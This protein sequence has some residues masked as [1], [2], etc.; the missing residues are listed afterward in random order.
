M[1][2]TGPAHE[3]DDVHRHLELG[4]VS[5]LEGGRPCG[6]GLLADPI[7]VVTCAHVV[8]T[9]LGR[10][11]RAADQPEATVPVAFPYAERVGREGRVVVWRPVG[12]AGG[13][14][15]VLELVEPAPPE[16]SPVRLVA[17][18]ALVDHAFVVWGFPQGGAGQ[19]LAEGVLSRRRGDDLVQMRAGDGQPVR[20]GYSGAPVWDEVLHGVVGIVTSSDPDATTRTAY[21]LPTDVIAGV[22]PDLP[23]QA[24]E[25]VDAAHIE[26]PEAR[27]VVG[28]RI[29]AA[30]ES[31]RDR[32]ELRRKLRELLLEGRRIICVT[33]RRGIGKSAVVAKVLAEF[34]QPDPARSPLDDLDGLVY[35]STRTQSGVLSLATVFDA[36]AS[37]ADDET[38]ARL[39]RRWDNAKGAALPA[40]WEAVRRTRVVV[41]LDNLDDV[42]D[43]DTGRLQALDLLQ[44]L[45]SVCRTPYPQRVVTT[46]QRSLDLPVELLPNVHEERLEEGLGPE[47]ALA[48]PRAMQGASPGLAAATDDQ[49]VDA[50]DRLHGVPR[51]LELLAR[52]VNRDPFFLDD[53]LA[54]DTAPG[55]L[56][57]ELVSRSFTGLDGVGRRVVALL[58]LAAVPLAEPD[59]ATM[60]AGTAGMAGTAG[61]AA[62][63][64]TADA[65]DV[66]RSVRALVA[67][68]QLG[69]DSVARHVRLHPLDADYVQH[70]LLADEPGT[71]VD[72]D[73][74]LA[75][76]YAAAR[77]PESTWRAVADVTPLR[78][79]FD[80][81]WRAGEHEAAMAVLAAAARFL[82][83]KDEAPSLL[84]AA[85]AA[86]GVG[87]G[88]RCRFFAEWCRYNAEFFEG[89][90][91]RAEGAL[92]ACRA[93]AA[94]AGMAERVPSLDVDLGAL[95]RHRED[96][97]AAAAMLQ[98]LV[99]SRELAPDVRAYALFEVGLSLCYLSRWAEAEEAATALA[100]FSTGTAV[101]AGAYDAL[102]AAERDDLLALARLGLG[103]YAGA[104]A[105]ADE[106]ISLYLDSPA[107]DNA[108]YLYNVKGIVALHGD[109]LGG[110]EAAFRSGATLGADYGVD[111]LEGICATNL[112]WTLL[113]AG[114]LD[115]AREAADRAA[116][117][118]AANAVGA[119]ATGQA[120]AALLARGPA[121]GGDPVAVRSA[122]ETATASSRGNADLYTPPDAVLAAL[123]ADLAGE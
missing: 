76:W 33:G 38:A 17:D 18:A 2:G 51:G 70:V 65:G 5:V 7:H 54:S 92:R 63:A 94:D 73:L 34:E 67:T 30:V 53:L 29:S 49:L 21:L 116:D 75:D 42:Q 47:D 81:R 87:A 48:L 62:M 111:R 97:A 108:G 90:L 37:L 93:L 61:S 113:R 119:A 101:V 85:A 6:A 44:F 15:A 123:L 46:S 56:L 74:R 27:R 35:L 86:D 110:A 84:A 120:L 105:V 8:N 112:A 72:L 95:F 4:F 118:L 14:V 78:R 52:E 96:P 122:L 109:D 98:P 83:R 64:G 91:E 89:S 45:E 39:R 25:A 107:Q 68:R 19:M 82:A 58:A 57:A 66:R 88:P 22:W 1:T 12:S 103:D 13:D 3:P 10:D 16:S 60:L 36:V 28:E 11:V 41:V 55:P 100:A 23:V 9:A 79:E 40:L 117:R 104:V 50:A 43:P 69:F 24:V 77:R 102:P 71:Q 26:R 59:I 114:R 106:G 121:A 80:H 99:A 32:D 31:W 115:E 20:A